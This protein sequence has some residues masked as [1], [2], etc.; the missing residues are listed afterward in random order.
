MLLKVFIEMDE[1]GVWNCWVGTKNLLPSC[2]ILKHRHFLLCIF[3]LSLITS[4]YIGFANET[5][6]WLVH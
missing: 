5:I 6:D 2:S 1:K 4:E 3:C